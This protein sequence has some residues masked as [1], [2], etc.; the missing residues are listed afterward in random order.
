MVEFNGLYS[1]YHMEAMCTDIYNDSVADTIFMA[2]DYARDG[3]ISEAI[4]LIDNFVGTCRNRGETFRDM[5]LALIEGADVAVHVVIDHDVEGVLQ[6]APVV[7]VSQTN[8]ENTA[9][10]IRND[11][12]NATVYSVPLVKR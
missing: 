9:K 7:H 8:A 2:M 10:T 5:L 4:G 1:Q 6:D 11:G 3:K 12:G